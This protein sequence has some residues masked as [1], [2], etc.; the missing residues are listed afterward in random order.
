MARRAAL[1][2]VVFQAAA[3]PAAASAED[4]PACAKYDEPLAYN[5][6]LASHGP[7]ANDVGK[8]P[9]PTS[10]LAMLR[11]RPN[12]RRARRLHGPP[13][14]GRRQPVGVAASTWNSTSN[15]AR[16]PPN[17]ERGAKA[18]G[19][20]G[21]RALIPARWEA[22][23]GPRMA[24]APWRGARKPVPWNPPYPS[25]GGAAVTPLTRRHARGPGKVSSRRV[26]LV[27]AG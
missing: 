3:W 22:R 14:A 12:T 25:A 18:R 21:R 2:L 17:D 15:S 16:P 8:P 4:D 26:I 24:P 11:P 23:R 10:Q 20:P 13:R 6:C 9:A 1:M 19:K 7:R 27:T 5:A